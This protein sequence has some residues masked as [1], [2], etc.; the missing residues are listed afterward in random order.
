MNEQSRRLG[1]ESIPRLVMLLSFPAFSAMFI[2]TLFNLI[3]TIFIARGVGTLGIAALSI[4]FPIQA[5]IAVGAQTFGVGGASIISRR[6]GAERL[7]GANK[8]FGHIVW[9]IL[10]FSIVLMV[11]AIVFLDP[12]LRAFGA[13]GQIL[14]YAKD[15]VQ[16]VLLGSIFNS[17]AAGTNNV[18]RSEGNA[19]TA[20]YT[21]VIGAALNVV[22]NPVFI[23]WLGLE[24]QG[25]AIATVISQSVTA[26]WLVHYFKSEKSSFSLHWIAWKP[27][28]HLVKDITLLGLPAFVAMASTSLTVLS[29]NWAL[30]LFGGATQVAVY[31]IINRLLFFSIMPING[32]VQGMQPIIGFNYGA[33]SIERVIQTFKFCVYIATTIAI[34]AWIGIMAVPGFLM[35]IF[36]AD[37]A[38]ISNGADALRWMFLIAPLIGLPL[39][40]GGMYQAVGKEK[41]AFVLSISRTVLFLLPLIFTLPH[42]LGIT[43]VW[44]SFALADGCAFFLTIFILLQDRHILF[45]YNEGRNAVESGVPR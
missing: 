25:A 24:M 39:V 11:T 32:I 14:P 12:L 31:G 29:V 37:A 42:F 21:M 9:L 17:F 5:I 15:Y 30:V 27:D 8:V 20:M 19:K 7:E 33:A 13:T 45:A 10:F 6:L 22:L 40:T 38:V 35:N 44:L 1:T 34:L 16:I 41:K 36:S 4:A 28:F 3:D 26:V 18:V 2:S 43:G 23:F